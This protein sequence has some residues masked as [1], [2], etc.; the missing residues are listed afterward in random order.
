MRDT[1]APSSRPLRDRTIRENNR[2]QRSCQQ[3]SPES[4]EQTEH[5]RNDQRRPDRHLCRAPHDNRLQNQSLHH[6]DRAIESKH[7]EES[8]HPAVENRCSRRP[9]ECQQRPKVRNELEQATQHRPQR[10]P[11]HVQIT[12]SE[13]PQ[14]S[15][16]DRVK[17]LRDQPTPQCAAGDGYVPGKL[18][19]SMDARALSA[20]LP[21]CYTE[22]ET[23]SWSAWQ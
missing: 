12:Q 9:K 11:R 1:S 19:N 2:Q 10:C 6:D 21:P 4:Y 7:P 20:S 18:H 23:P 15:D 22:C 13:P 16:A 14:Q 8:F 3:Q 5:D 17:N